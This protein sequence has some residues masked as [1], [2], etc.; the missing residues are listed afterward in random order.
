MRIEVCEDAAAAAS[1]AAEFL[2]ERIESAIA[3]KG[4]AAIALSG[5]TTP[6]GMLG[7]LAT[8]D[9]DWQRVHIFQVDERL[10]AQ[11]DDRRNMR[12][13]R[14][15]FAESGIP[16]IR[17]HAMPADSASPAAAAEEYACELRAV[18]GTPLVLDAVHLGLGEDGHT[19]SLFPGDTAIDAIGEVALSG[20]HG[21]VRRMTL[22]L[23]VINRAR[24]RLWLVT[25][26]S[27]REIVR[28]LLEPGSDLIASRVRQDHSVLI[29]DR[30]AAAVSK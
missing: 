5:G 23:Q 26:A 3:A 11:N 15:A 30:D 17:L 16:A 1:Q 9:I 25:G 28:R 22:T 13:I 2:I 19:A 6:V 10:V 24:A 12:S 29:L 7:Q 4:I 8:A 20:V 14:A 21:G 18:A 27:K